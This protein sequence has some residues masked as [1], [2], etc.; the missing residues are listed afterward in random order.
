MPF[1]EN[2]GAKLY[3]RANGEGDPILLIMG[4]SFTHQMWFRLLPA[5]LPRYRA[6]LFDNRGM[7]LSS[8]PPGPYGIPKMARDALAVM[9]AA[10]VETAHI[11]GASMGG[12]IAQEFAL[13]YPGRVR[14]LVLACTSHSGLWGRWPNIRK[15]AAFLRFDRNSRERAIIPLLYAAHTPPERIEEDLRIRS[16]CNWSPEGFR[17]QFSS[18]LR[19]SAYPRL[20]RLQVQTLVVHGKEDHLIPVMNGQRLA[21]RIPG[22]EFKVIHDAGHI[23]TTDQPEVCQRVMLDFLAQRS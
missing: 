15:L 7:G 6:I 20:P 1:V 23:L 11:A 2:E 5:L 17:R 19:W 3:W 8:V 18:I 22:A 13:T 16:S 4:L 14:S 9:D 12:M 21:D 10:G